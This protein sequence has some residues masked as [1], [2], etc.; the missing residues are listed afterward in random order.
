[1]NL[2]AILAFA[3]ILRMTVFLIW[4]S[5][6]FADEIYQI[7]E[8]AHKLAFGSGVLATWDFRSGLRSWVLPTVLAGIMKTTAWMG[9]GSAGYTFAIALFAS[10]LS[11]FA[12]WFAY[13]WCRRTV[14]TS[15]GLLAAFVAAAWYEFVYFGPHPFSEFIS[16]NILLPVIYFGSLAG[17]DNSKDKWRLIAVGIGLGIVV[18]LRLQMAPA[19]FLAGIWIIR[20]NWRK[21]VGPVLAGALAAILVFGIADTVSWGVPFHSYYASVQQNVLKDRASHFGTMSFFGALYHL[22]GRVG[23]LILL[24]LVGVRRSP[25]LGWLCLAILV[26][27]L[28]IPHKE[29]RYVYP[30]LPLLLT[31][32]VMGLND[33]FVFLS[34][35]LNLN[36]L[37]L[38]KNRLLAAA[39]L[40]L[41][42]LL[43]LRFP[44]WAQGTGYL[45]A[46]RYI[47]QTPAICGIGIEQGDWQIAG[48]YTWLHRPIPIFLAPNV[49]GLT[50]LAVD[51][52]A[53]VIPTGQ[54][55]PSGSFFKIRCW[56]NACLYKREGDCRLEHKEST[57]EEVIP[58]EQ[59]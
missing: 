24:A 36:K 26:P 9:G 19:V 50:A 48:G 17:E 21:R 41:S 34:E 28:L 43:A 7:Q 58:R 25:I 11:L 15:C 33:T 30:M 46:F 22:F 12:V 32:A 31:L 51:L 8:P 52:N 35:K 49:D 16:G 14:N 42:L 55:L 57:I 39:F 5:V 53:I 18:G 38:H 37:A 1:M 3:L 56:Q 2:G 13:A 45:K 10:I 40:M 6:Y 27:H 4:P 47:S 59:E 23:P 20:G 44:F 54:N 29:Y